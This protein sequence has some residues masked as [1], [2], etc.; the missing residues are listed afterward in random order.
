MFSKHI[1]LKLH[2]ISA[3]VG[4]GSNNGKINKKPR[5]FWVEL[6]M[7]E[8]S[9]INVGSNFTQSDNEE[10]PEPHTL[11]HKGGDM[12]VGNKVT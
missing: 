4:L 10:E 3:S 2:E 6:I 12:A 7:S 9:L 11:S 1:K 5:R 8:L